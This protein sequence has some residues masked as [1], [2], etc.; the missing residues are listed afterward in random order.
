[1][2]A[3]ELR[4]VRAEHIDPI[5]PDE[6][7]ESDLPKGARNEL[8]T[9]EATNQEFVAR[10]LV[11]ASVLIDTDPELAHQHAVSAARRGGR[12]A[13]VRETLAITA[14]TIG[15]YAL[16][17]R[18]LRTYRRISGKE[19]QLALMIDSERGLG[20]PD[21]ALELGRAADR[22]GLGPAELVQVAIAMS[23]ARL[24]QG[25][26]DLALAELEIPQL[27]P[28]RAYSYSPAL[29]GAYA[30]VLEELGRESEAERWTALATRAQDAL[31]AVKHDEHETIEVITEGEF[32]PLED[33]EIDG[34]D[35]PTEDAESDTESTHAA[36]SIDGEDAAEATDAP[37][38]SDD[39]DLEAEVD[40]LL[41]ASGEPTTDARSQSD[42]ETVD[43]A[44][45][46]L[47]DALV[48]EV[49]AEADEIVAEAEAGDDVE[50]EAED[51]LVEAEAADEV[52]EVQEEADEIVAA[53]EELEELAEDEDD[54]PAVL[55][56]ELDVVPAAP[57]EEAGVEPT[58]QGAAA[59]VSEPEAASDAEAVDEND[60]NEGKRKGDEPEP[61]FDL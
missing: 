34:E 22:T 49:E 17:L 3:R 40:E 46:V 53:A 56:V 55:E 11:M 26:P 59:E 18:E 50:A 12:I 2:L 19:D 6:V 10:H 39:D 21:R 30:T 37:Y 41:A 4:P 9:L 45:A 35:A 58:Q 13:M 42:A 1:M 20:R 36:A 31:D 7:S 54:A 43:G 8:K 52:A 25:S 14:Y 27:D 57:E 38:S 23:G 60:D 61:L 28:K 48:A 29:F 15:D 32:P 47:D 44:A 5:V 16:A 24:D 33:D 51:I